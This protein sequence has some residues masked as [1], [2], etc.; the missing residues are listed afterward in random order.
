VVLDDVSV[1]DGAVIAAGAL[2][3]KDVPPRA[4]AAGH[5][6]VVKH[7]NYGPR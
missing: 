6:A 7:P 1:G 5:P 2:V 3:R 4:L